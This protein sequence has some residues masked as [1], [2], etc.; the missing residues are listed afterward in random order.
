L[1][2]RKEVE[3]YSAASKAVLSTHHVSERATKKT[4]FKKGNTSNKT[5]VRKRSATPHFFGQ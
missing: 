5:E 3:G 2:L 4:A 1:L